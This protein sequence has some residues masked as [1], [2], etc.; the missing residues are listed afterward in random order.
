[1]KTYLEP[2]Y[3]LQP[4]YTSYHNHKLP[5]DEILGLGEKLEPLVK[6]EPRGDST[7]TKAVKSEQDKLLSKL[8][9]VIVESKDKKK[10]KKRKKKN[11]KKDRKSG[12]ETE[13]MISEGRVSSGDDID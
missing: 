5:I 12:V 10:D 4:D 6:K 11:K 13:E 7:G 9:N 1:M 8:M 3:K 2:L